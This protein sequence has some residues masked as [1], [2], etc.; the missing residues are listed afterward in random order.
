MLNPPIQQR[1]LTPD[2]RGRL[3]WSQEEIGGAIDTHQTVV[4][5]ILREMAVLPKG[6]KKQIETCLGTI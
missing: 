2:L 5:D 4:G 6:I 3:G 1:T